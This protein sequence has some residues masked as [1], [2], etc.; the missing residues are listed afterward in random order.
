MLNDKD[1]HEGKD[2][3]KDKTEDEDTGKDYGKVIEKTGGH[4]A[5]ITTQVRET[6]PPTRQVTYV[7]EPRTNKNKLQQKQR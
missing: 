1:K 4:D 7:S 6:V 5:N 3:H 2:K